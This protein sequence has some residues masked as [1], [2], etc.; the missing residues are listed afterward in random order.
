MTKSETTS[1]SAYEHQM[2]R[3]ARDRAEAVE[4]N[5]AR[6]EAQAKFGGL[7]STSAGQKLKEKAL[8]G[9]ID[10]IHRQ[11]AEH[12][13]AKGGPIPIWYTAIDGLDVGIVA[14]TALIV[15]LDAVGSNWSWNA[16]QGYAGNALHTA[17]FYSKFGDR[18]GKK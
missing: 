11:I 9:V 1:Q 18:K 13:A 3:E 2:A 6:R 12:K 4:L 10:E 8:E 7:S 16:T 17:V 5:K 14:E 15:C